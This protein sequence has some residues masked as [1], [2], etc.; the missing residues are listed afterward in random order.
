V[1]SKKKLEEAKKQFFF[2]KFLKGEMSDSLIGYV[3]VLLAVFFFG[4]NFL[5]TKK[6]ETGDGLFF[7]VPFALGIWTTSLVVMFARPFPVRFYPT[8]M[9]GGLIWET[10]NILSIPI[11]QRI[12]MALGLIIW[13]TSAL[14]I[15][16]FTGYFGLFGLNSQKD[17]IHS[18]PLDLVGLVFAI[19]S[20]VAA[21]NVKK[22]KGK[23]ILRNDDASMPFVVDDD[24]DEDNNVSSPSHTGSSRHH[25]EGVAMAIL[26]GVFFGSN[27]D[28]P[29]WIQNHDHK[30]SQNSLDYV[31]S[32]FCGILLTSTTYFLI[33]CVY[34][35]NKPWVNAKLFL[36]AFVSGLGW[37]TAQIGWFLAN[38]NLGYTTAFP[39][40][41]IGPGF[42]GSLWDVFIYKEITGPKNMRWLVVVFFF[43]IVSATC[44]VL[45][46]N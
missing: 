43:I 28:P 19:F 30:A 1:S 4:S 24:D 21:I 12:G 25:V 15:G 26:A 16:W 11:I 27:F 22:E 34:K 33:Y 18:L 3:G 23:K 32:H 13:G 38:S 36:P 2:F 35:R 6:Y 31:F 45:S 17:D 8:A 10:G 42:V 40:V 29:T 9:I 44:T 37:G 5:V 20:L 46:R 14:C 7:Q 39:L 41:L